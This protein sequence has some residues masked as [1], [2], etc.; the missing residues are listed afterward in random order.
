[1]TTPP[2]PARPAE[3]DIRSIVGRVRRT[4]DEGRTRPLE[5]RREQLDGLLRLLDRE[6]NTLV[7]A[8]AA[9]VGK[10]RLEGWATDLGATAADLRHLRRHTRAWAKPRRIRLS[11]SSRPG[12][13]EV[14]PEPLGVGLV[15]APWNY[16]VQ[17][18]I[19]P[20]ATAIAAG[21]AVVVKPSELAP[22]TSAQLARLIP[23]YVDPEAIAVIDGGVDAARAL[24]DERWDHI[25]FTGSTRVG[26]LVME[27]AA[28][29]LTPVTLELG[30]KSPVIVDDSAAL[31]V[32]ARRIAWGKWLNS[33]QTCIAPDYVLA[34]PAVRDRFVD[35]VTEAFAEFADGAVRLTPHYGRIVSEAHAI[36]IESLL[37]GHGGQVTTGGTVDIAARFVEPTIVV[38]P[39]LDSTLM[40]DEIFGPI[41]P[42]VTVSSTEEAIEFV[43]ARP[44]P[45]ALY[46]F[47]QDTAVADQV[48]GSTSSG[49]AVVN[50]V[51]LHKTPTIPFGGVG[52][53]GTGRYHGRAGFDH[54]SN[55]KGVLRKPTR[56]DPSILYP[57][58]TRLK[59]RIIRRLL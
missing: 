12:R 21:N 27:A 40:T 26:R 4:F 1:M 28:R 42:V 15:I 39:D 57:P 33:G 54:Y 16:P 20:L 43:N 11:L 52:P 18:V 2:A 58:Y 55:L 34:T 23:R 35:L 45:L 41:L 19:Q 48:I 14:V 46:V 5:W 6:E 47:A 31:E 51:V 38:D 30:G 17:L 56:P 3:P 22:E 53:S 36:R 24:L 32:A 25:F 50:H 10:P 37:A 59:E 7:D 9:D 8:L 49:G 44:K 13:A 29:N